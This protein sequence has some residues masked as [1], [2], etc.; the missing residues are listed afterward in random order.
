[1]IIDGKKIADELQ[2]ELKGLIQKLTPKKPGL[3]FI[4]VGHHAPSHTYVRMKK[5]GCLEVGIYS[6]TYELEETVSEEEL[7]SL[8]KRC[9]KNPHI[10][11]ILVQ[12]PLPSHLSEKKVIEAIDPHKDVDGFHPL[13]IG[14]ALLG[15]DDGFLSCTPLGIITLLE[16]AEVQV[17]GKHALILGRSNIVGKPLASLLMQKKPHRNA[18]VTVAHSQTTDLEN[19]CKTADILIAAIG[20]PLFVKKSFIKKGAT[21]IDVGINILEKDGKKHIV[22]DVDF[23]EVAPLC[24]RITPVPKGVGPMTITM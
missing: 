7:I 14:K 24:S 16:K 21:V 17:E 2:L 4:L 5:K 18:T 1:M 13:N 12:Q 8:I 9:N 11:G 20:K 15:Q 6:E 10:H 23:E 19:L 22:G 3:A